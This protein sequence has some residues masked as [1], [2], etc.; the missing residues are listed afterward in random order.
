MT[1]LG[2][3]IFTRKSF[4]KLTLDVNR[5]HLYKSGDFDEKEESDR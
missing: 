5:R 4:I 1:V 3:V 2:V